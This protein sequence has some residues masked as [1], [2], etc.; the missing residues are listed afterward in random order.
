M[1]LHKT[2]SNPKRSRC[3]LQ[4]QVDK[5]IITKLLP[6]LGKNNH[7]ETTSQAADP[8]HS[9]QNGT[10]VPLRTLL[11]LWKTCVAMVTVSGL[12]NGR[13]SILITRSAQDW[14]SAWLLC[15][16]KKS[17]LGDL[18]LKE[19]YH[20]PF[21]SMKYKSQ[22]SPEYPTDQLLY[23]FENVYFEWKQKHACVYVSLNA[24]ELLFPAPFSRIELC[25]YSSYLWYSAKTHLFGFDYHA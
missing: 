17:I 21:Y 11:Q 8:S 25:L 22:M 14:D 19:T 15:R 13:K 1:G 4:C 2:N 9:F 7:Q 20:V 3:S 24:N 10:S 18:A 12:G 5:M 16:K 6:S 23:P